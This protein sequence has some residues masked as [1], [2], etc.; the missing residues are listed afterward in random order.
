LALGGLLYDEYGNQRITKSN[1]SR[2]QKGMTRTQVEEIIGKPPKPSSRVTELYPHNG[3]RSHLT[4][5]FTRRGM[6][7]IY[8]DQNDRVRE[9]GFYQPRK[10]PGDLDPLRDFLDAFSGWLK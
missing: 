1:C 6:I 4:E 7:E 3:L 2:I 10:Q 8:F 5:W 9:A